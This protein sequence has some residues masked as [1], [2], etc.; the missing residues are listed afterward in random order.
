VVLRA[1]G[2][3]VAASIEPSDLTP[4][5]RS[6]APAAVEVHAPPEP[7]TL[8][9]ELARVLLRILQSVDHTRAIPEARCQ[10]DGVAS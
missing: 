4:R 7:P 3:T 1:L 6:N 2:F 8:T 10:T 5:R 9:P